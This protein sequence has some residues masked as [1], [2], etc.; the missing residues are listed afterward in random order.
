KPP[1]GM[2]LAM[3]DGKHFL[4]GQLNGSITM[5]SYQT[6]APVK[7]FVGARNLAD[8]MSVSADGKRFLSTAQ[9]GTRLWDVATGR[10]LA[11]LQAPGGFGAT[12]LSADGLCFA[13][14][15]DGVE[16]NYYELPKQ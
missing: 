3:P 5:Y 14:A 9:D 8:H 16:H 7:Q 15:K 6:G 11:A 12:K 4:A 1:S 2:L 13:T 10:S